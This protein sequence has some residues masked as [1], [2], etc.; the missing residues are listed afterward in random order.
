[1]S[2]KHFRE[3]FFPGFK[4]VVQGFKQL[5]LYVIKHTD[6]NLWPILDMIVEAGID[7][8]DPIDPAGGM[9]LAEVKAVYG[10]RIAVKGNVD[11]AH[12]M[13]FGTPEEVV[14]ATKIALQKGMPGGGFI[15]SS[16]N[17]I[18]SSVKPENYAAMVKTLKKYGSY[19][20]IDRTAG[21]ES[22]ADLD[23]G[24]LK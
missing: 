5:G 16:S 10:D 14:A 11:C 23:E 13:T 20:E 18:H 15:L 3:L 2:P 6:G 9:D 1:M 7:C 19:A 24:G 22:T 4:G 12:L 17:S 8:L 21:N